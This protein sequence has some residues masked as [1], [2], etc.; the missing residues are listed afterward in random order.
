MRNWRDVPN[1]GWK[2]RPKTQSKRYRSVTGYPSV[3]LPVPA[4]MRIGVVPY[5]L[6]ESKEASRAFAR[7]RLLSP[8]SA[9]MAAGIAKQKRADIGIGITAQ[10]DS[11]GLTAGGPTANISLWRIARGGRLATLGLVRLWRCHTQARL[12]PWINPVEG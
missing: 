2:Q 1:G 4:R 9:E 6:A 7:R 10:N 12:Q 3:S 11:A 5:R 8:G